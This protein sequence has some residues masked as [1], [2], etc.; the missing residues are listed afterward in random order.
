MVVDGLTRVNRVTY[1]GLSSLKKTIYRDDTLTLAAVD[2]D[3]F[4]VEKSS[5]SRRMVKLKRSGD[6]RS[7]G[8]GRVR[9]Q[10]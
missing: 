10:C 7:A 6:S 1:D 9:G 2:M 3:E 4:Y 8:G 5:T